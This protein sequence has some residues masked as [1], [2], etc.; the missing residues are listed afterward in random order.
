MKIALITDQHFGV[1]NDSNQFH[2][3]F[4]KFYME[5]F[6][7][8][9]EEIGVEAIIS[10]GDTFDRRKYIN[11]HSLE[12]CRHYWFDQI[13]DR[14]LPLHCLVGNHDIYYKNTNRVNAADL[15]LQ[16]YPNVIA[17]SSPKTVTLGDLEILMMPWINSENY[18][19]CMKIAEETNASVMMSHLELQGFE[20]YR[21]S[22][23]DHGL[24][25][26]VFSKFDYVFSGHFHHKSSRD[27]IHYL[28]SP[29]EMTWSDYNDPRGFHIFDT[30]TRSLT[31]IRNPYTMFH[32]V[33]YDDTEKTEQE[34]LDQDFSYLKDCYVKIVVKQKN[35]PYVFDIFVDKLNSGLPA[36]TQVVEDN[37]NLDMEDDSDIVNEAEDTVSIVKHYIENLKLDDT[38]TSSLKTLFEGLYQDALSIE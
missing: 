33:F 3:H 7:P 18:E 1:R 14:N 36:A 38:K 5:Y 22:V 13:R 16:E 19:E 2:D 12:R 23:N 25:H 9:I 35:N 4:E 31:Y 17:Y 11:Y 15:L 21:G 27:N 30:E 37:F 32:K 34:I 8:T 10:L 24:S 28:G 26:K 6:F 29:Y 20:M